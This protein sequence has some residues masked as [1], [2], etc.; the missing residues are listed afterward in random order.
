ME[1]S[2]SP[3]SPTPV[4]VTVVTAAPLNI[5]SIFRTRCPP[6]SATY[7]SI[8]QLVSTM[9]S[10]IARLRGALNVASVPS[11]SDPPSALLP[12]SVEVRP[13]VL[14]PRIV[15]PSATITCCSAKLHATAVGPR[16]NAPVPVPSMLPELPCPAKMTIVERSALSCRTRKPPPSARYTTPPSL[17]V[18]P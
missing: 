2:P 1:Q 14:T 18:R 8:F 10:F 11:P 17:T 4:P 7:M 5:A 6:V 12:A 13:P 3:V 16:K 9:Y 15:L